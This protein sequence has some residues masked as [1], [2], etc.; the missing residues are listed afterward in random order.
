MKPLAENEKSNPRNHA[1]KAI[2]NT[3]SINGER[4][5][6]SFTFDNV[7]PADK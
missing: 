7:F 1:W 5:K 2:G 6:E 4:Y 3:I